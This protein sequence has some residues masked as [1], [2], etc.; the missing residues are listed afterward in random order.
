MDRTP[1]FNAVFPGHA[2]PVP[3]DRHRQAGGRGLRKR[4]F[5]SIGTIIIGCLPSPAMAASELTTRLIRCGEQSCLQING[6]RGD[7]AATVSINGHDVPFEGEH[8]W[9]V[10]LPVEVVR[11]WSAPYAR[12]IEVSLHDTETQREAIASVD[13]P[14]G[15]LG[16]VTDLASL[17]ISAR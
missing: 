17:V 14:I 12:T 7:P 16:G 3:P 4:A 6:R 9:R 10:R 2:S 11:Q 5:A 13:L 15:L 8:S 1:I